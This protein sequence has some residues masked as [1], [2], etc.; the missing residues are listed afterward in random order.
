MR[1]EAHKYLDIEPDNPVTSH[2]SIFFMSMGIGIY[3]TFFKYLQ[4]LI[5]RVYTSY[6]QHLFQLLL[7]SDCSPVTALFPETQFSSTWYILA[8]RM[9]HASISLLTQTKYCI[10]YIAVL[11]F[12]GSSID[13][14]DKHWSGCIHLPWRDE[15]IIQ[16]RIDQQHEK[17]QKIN[18][19]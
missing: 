17:L 8:H 15:G 18:G 6:M 14:A 19:R 10:V 2:V 12:L 1:L 7:S 9:L 16:K 11:G 5:K 13:P 4:L 3:I